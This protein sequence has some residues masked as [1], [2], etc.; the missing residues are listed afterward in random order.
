MENWGLI[1]YRTTAILFDEE[2]SDARY[3]N[4]ISYVVAHGMPISRLTAINRLLTSLRT[5]PSVVWKSCNN[6]LVERTMAQ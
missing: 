3:K 1:T 6:G 4:Q 5:R 2:H